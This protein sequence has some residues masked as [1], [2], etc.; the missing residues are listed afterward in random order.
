MGISS[1]VA[2]SSPMVMSSPMEMSSPM[3]MSRENVRISPSECRGRVASSVVTDL[4][5]QFRLFTARLHD[6]APLL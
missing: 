3:G 4:Y 5:Q 6:H 2:M 1:S